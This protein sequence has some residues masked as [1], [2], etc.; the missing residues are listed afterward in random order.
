MRTNKMLISLALL[1]TFALHAE[2][3]EMD[4]LFTSKTLTPEAALSVARSALESCRE[5]GFQVS[6]AVVDAGGNL[7]VVLR[8]KLAGVSSSEGAILKA[9]TSVSFRSA[10]T[11]LADAVNSNIEASGIKQ[12]PGIL[13]LG[14]GVTIQAS[15]SMVGAVGVAGAPDG[16]ADE[17]CALDGIETIQELLEFAD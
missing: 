17:K 9:K 16:K 11:S 7:Q 13:V 15:G 3:K 4:V 8:D 6:V 1:G 5:S 12:L 2:E 14:G 10:T